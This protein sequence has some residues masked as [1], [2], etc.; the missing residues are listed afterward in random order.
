MRFTKSTRSNKNAL[1]ARLAKQVAGVLTRAGAQQVSIE[2]SRVSASAYVYLP[3]ELDPKYGV[4]ESVKI[5]I[6]DHDD[7]SGDA[8]HRIWDEDAADKVWLAQTAEILAAHRPD[9]RLAGRDAA[10]LALQAAKD[11]DSRK[12]AQAARAAAIARFQASK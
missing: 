9:L 1:C 3:I 10:A 5:R 2:R 8:D 11:A 4:M 6:S 12:K 7:H